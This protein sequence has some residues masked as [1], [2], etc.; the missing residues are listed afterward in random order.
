[1]STEDTKQEEKRIDEL[2]DKKLLRKMQIIEG[3]DPDAQQIVKDFMK[4]DNVIERTNLPTTNAVLCITQLDF[5]SNWLYRG[6]PND[7]FG[8]LRDSLAVS[9]MARKGEKAN[10]FVEM[11]RENRDIV[12][13]E[14]S[15]IEKKVP[16]IFGRFRG[17]SVEE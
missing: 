11:F 6:I 15:E 13:V 14:G 3:K 4:M 5:A 10:Q 16:G 8:S 2:N 12:A 17:G 9:F 1:M 7:P